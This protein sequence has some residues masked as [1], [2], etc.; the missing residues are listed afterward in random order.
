MGIDVVVTRAAGLDIA[1]ASLVACVRVPAPSGG[2]QT[3][4]KKFSTVTA[5]LLELAAWLAGHPS[6]ADPPAT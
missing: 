6:A 1:K 2:F 3:I 4:K 5:G